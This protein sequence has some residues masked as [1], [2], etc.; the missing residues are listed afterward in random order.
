ML[1]K[2]WLKLDLRGEAGVATTLV[3]TSLLLV[4]GAAATT[5]IDTNNDYQQQAE[6][7]AYQAMAEVATGV[8][9]IDVL[10]HNSNGV[11]TSL[12]ILLRLSVGSPV[13][14]LNEMTI[15]ATTAVMS[16]TYILNTTE[17]DL[18]F[19]AE[20]VNIASGLPKWSNNGDYLMGKGD[21]VR[22]TL[23]GL[24]VS[25]GQSI[26]VNFIPSL[27]QQNFINL[28][29]PDAMIGTVVTLR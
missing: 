23:T 25:H 21:L 10:G 15:V 24:S 9:V 1:P 3:I 14:N 4:S 27:G 5:V 18:K 20:Q 16:K 8:T 11:I 28:D 19:K 17:A 29:V 2:Y 26:R 12:E 7:T 6:E 13:I 22:V